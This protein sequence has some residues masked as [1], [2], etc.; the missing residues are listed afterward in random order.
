MER[1]IHDLPAGT[2]AA[3][4]MPIAPRR[5]DPELEHRGRAADDEVN[6]ANIVR[7]R[8][9]TALGSLAASGVDNPLRFFVDLCEIEAT[10]RE[11]ETWS[12]RGGAYWTLRHLL[13][14]GAAHHWALDV[15]EAAIVS[16]FE[17]TEGD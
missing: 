9:V 5:S 17:L 12:S 1:C 16:A 10:S 2:C 14:G 4:A 13:D 8:V 15:I 6:R 7:P 3:C 11:I